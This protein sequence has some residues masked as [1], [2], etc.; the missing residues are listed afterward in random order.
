MDAADREPLRAVL[1][2]RLDVAGLERCV[3][4]RERDG[5][6]LSG[7]IVVERP[8]VDVRYA[9]HCD[10]GW[11]TRAVRVRAAGA[12]GERGLELE[13]DGRG[14]WSSGGRELEALRGLLDVDLQ[15][16]PATNTLP[17]RRL[18]LAL[19]QEAEVTAAWVRFPELD[20]VPLTQRYARVEPELYRYASPGFSAEIAVDELGLVTRYGALWERVTAR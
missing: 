8:C 20:V 19:G 1:W 16:T 18:A 9:L 15:L 3:V 6:S 13:A 2:K 14:R 17:I 7:T 4:A 12:A 11:R 10:T 5:W